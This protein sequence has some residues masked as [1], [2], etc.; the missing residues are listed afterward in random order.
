MVR[1]VMVRQV[2]V[3]QVMV[4]QVMVRQVMVRQV[5]VRQVMVRQVMVRQVMV[6]QVMVRQ[7]MVRQVMDRTGGGDR[8]DCRVHRQTENKLQNRPVICGKYG[9]TTAAKQK[10]VEYEEKITRSRNRRRKRNLSPQQLASAKTNI[11]I[12]AH[13][14]S[15]VQCPVESQQLRVL[16]FVRVFPCRLRA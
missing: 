5:M 7:V 10:G 2:M 8:Q 3:R 11:S 14:Q 1:Q 15:L 12:T 6:R 9:N 13:T 4:R 16:C